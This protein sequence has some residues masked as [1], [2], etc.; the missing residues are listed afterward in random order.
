M[1]VPFE[2]QRGFTLGLLSEIAEDAYEPGY[3]AQTSS[4]SSGSH[5]LV[6]AAVLLVIGLVVG[7]SIDQTLRSRPAADAERAQLVQQVKAAETRVADQRDRSRELRHVIDNL[8]AQVGANPPTELD[9]LETSAGMRAVA[10]PGLVIILDDAPGAPQD[11][12]ILDVDLRQA[13]NGLWEAGAEAVAINDYRL[14]TITAIRSAGDA[15]TVDYRSLVPPYKIEAIGDPASFQARFAATS[16]GSW[17]I[18]LR[19]NYHARYEL[20]TEKVVRLPAGSPVELRHVK[21]EG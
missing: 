8:A 17:L 7:A 10:G 16:A 14:T 2:E 13:V 4:A 20:M 15:I 5:R 12:R 19:E 3:R 1:S 9:L 21:K 6:V 18:Y 11:A